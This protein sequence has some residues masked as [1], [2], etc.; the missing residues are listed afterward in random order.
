RRRRRRLH[1]E[2][3]RPHAHHARRRRARRGAQRRRGSGL[4]RPVL[5]L[6]G[7]VPRTAP[8]AAPAARGLVLS[9]SGLDAVPS[10][11]GKLGQLEM[12]DLAHNRLAAV[13]DDLG[14]LARLDV[15]YLGDNRLLAVP[16]AVRT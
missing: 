7:R 11:V 2:G 10:W 3:L 13:P 9:E 15:L 1:A 5:D 6:R 16:A 14:A 12:L 4:S 8:P